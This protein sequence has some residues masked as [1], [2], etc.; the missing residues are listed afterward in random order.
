MLSSEWV[1]LASGKFIHFGFGPVMTRWLYVFVVSTLLVASV[2]ATTA[3]PVDP[4]VITGSGHE[5]TLTDGTVEVTAVGRNAR[6]H[7]LFGFP[8]TSGNMKC[9]LGPNGDFGSHRTAPA[10][11]TDVGEAVA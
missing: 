5:T 6:F 11:V 9:T 7:P 1:G 10:N 3:T 4:D 2:P 8:V